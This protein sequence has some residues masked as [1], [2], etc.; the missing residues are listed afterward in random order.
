MSEKEYLKNCSPEAQRTAML[1]IVKEFIHEQKGQEIP[2]ERL[3]VIK[4]H[5][6]FLTVNNQEVARL[7]S[8]MC[9]GEAALM[10]HNNKRLATIRCINDCYLGTLSKRNFNLTLAKIERNLIDRKVDFILTCQQMR[11]IP[12]RSLFQLHY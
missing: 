11:H 2:E 8:G 6:K 4:N 5:I 7:S 9:F 10:N 12:Y 3:A 1:G